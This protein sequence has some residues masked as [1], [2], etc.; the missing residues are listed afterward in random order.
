[1]FSIVSKVVPNITFL[2]RKSDMTKE[3][4]EKVLKAGANVVFG[5]KN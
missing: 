4:I 3:R 1:M 5:I 2:C